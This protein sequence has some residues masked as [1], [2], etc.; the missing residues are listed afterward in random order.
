MRQTI[1]AEAVVNQQ[2]DII[3]ALLTNGFLDIFSGKQPDEPEDGITDQTTLLV[4]CRF[5]TFTEPKD[6]SIFALPVTDG[7]AIESGEATWA[8]CFC[9]DHKTAVMDVSVGVKNANVTLTTTKIERGKTMQVLEYEH[10]VPKIT[11]GI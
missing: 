9:A 1:L 6:G 10:C 11:P 3:A 7:V 5:S 8:R 2:C 4:S